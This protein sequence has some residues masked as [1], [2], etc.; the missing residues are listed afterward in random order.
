MTAKP[1][2]P[3][4]IARNSGIS[5]NCQVATWFR[6]A[7][8]A[9]QLSPYYVDRSTDKSRE[10]DMLV[11]KSMRIPAPYGGRPKFL[12]V[13]LYVE[14]KYVDRN[15]VFWFDRPDEDRTLKLL[16]STGVFPPRNSY[17]REHRYVEKG[18]Q[19]AKLFATEHSRGDSE[20]PIFRT[21]NQVLTGFFHSRGRPQLVVDEPEGD[22]VRLHYPVVVCSSFSKFFKTTVTWQEQPAPLTD[23]F[24]LEVDYSYIVNNTGANKLEF[25]L[26][27]FVAFDGLQGFVDRLAKEHEAALI[28]L[29]PN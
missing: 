21:I 9:V 7:G 25:C 29:M 5:F 4:D 22:V 24:L 8:W 28:L 17:T 12:H 11:E 27:D 19:V 6:K 2:T 1:M 14:C 15:V 3:E 10:I 20:E 23:R 26:I 13:R 16:E 18:T